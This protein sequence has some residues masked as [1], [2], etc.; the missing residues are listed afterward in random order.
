MAAIKQHR[1][2]W[3]QNH[4]GQLRTELYSG[5]Q[6]AI[7]AYDVNAQSVGR[8][9]ILPS[10]FTGGPCYMMQHYQN[11][12]TIF[13]TMGPPIFFVTFTCNPKWLEITNELLLGQRS[14]DRPVLITRVFKIKLRQLLED[15]KEKQILGGVIAEKFVE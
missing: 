1:F 6:D 5:I 2:T 13:R 11:G 4:Q 3:Y 14:E 7:N 15:F 12:I 10:S 8:R 9:Y